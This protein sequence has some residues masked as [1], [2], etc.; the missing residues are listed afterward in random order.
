MLRYSTGDPAGA[1]QLVDAAHRQAARTGSP[2][3]AAVLHARASRAHARAGNNLASRR[4]EQAMFDAY[5]RAGLPDNEPACVYWINR[6]ELHGW[7]ATNALDLRDPR[8][9][10]THH[11]AVTAAHRTGTHDQS[12]PRTA[13]LR[14]TR[15][16]DAHLALGNLDAAVHTA[17][18]AVQALGGV[19]SARGTSLLTGLR[20]KLALH[21][22]PLVR[23]FL[24]ST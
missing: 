22:T 8:R 10:L 2:R 12:H 13:A 19:T 5:D 16:A 6:D 3:M 23:D 20:K 21:P 17:T 15:E 4:A 9:A 24:E 1:L 18:R 14:L 7:A 11:A